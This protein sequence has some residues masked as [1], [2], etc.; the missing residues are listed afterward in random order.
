MNKKVLSVLL[1]I[2]LTLSLFAGCSSSLGNASEGKADMVVLGT[3]YTV[4]KD[5]RTASAAAIKDGKF[6]YVGNEDGIQEYIADSTEVLTLEEGMVL[7]SFAEGHGHGHEG[8]VGYLYQANLYEATSVEEYVRIIED[9]IKANP[10]LKFIRGAG[11][12]NGYCPPGGPT[13]EMLDAIDTDLPIAIV[14]GDHH[15]YWVNSKALELMGVNADTP[16]VSGGVIERDGEG[17]PTGTFR[18]NAQDLV[19]AIIPNYTVEEYK[20]GILAYQEEVVQYG[21]TAYYEPMI[22]LDGGPNL[23][24]AYK[25]L[26]EENKL[27][28]RVFGGYMILP[29][30]TALEE[31]D[32]CRELMEETAGGYFAVNSIKILV[33]GVVEGRTAYLLKDYADEPGYVGEP[34]WEPA[35]LNEFFAKADAMGIT[36]HTHSIGDAA[37]KM[38]VDACQYAYE[39]NGDMGNRHA[40]THLQV[41]RPEDI[42]RMADLNMVASVNTYWFCKEPGYFY[43]LEVPYLGEERANREYPMKSFFDAGIVVATASDFPVTVPSIPLGAIQTGVTRCDR[44]GDPN[45]LQNPD[46]RVTVEQMIESCTINP[47]YQLFSEES[48]GS[49]EVGKSADLIVLDKN[50]LELDSFEIGGA[51]V[52]RTILEGQTIFERL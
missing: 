2:A 16:D 20:A 30:D 21:I 38:T 35:Q 33:D 47:A 7:P 26:D 5:Q 8:G 14:S 29:G 41:V 25:E 40:I 1:A 24:Q 46:E 31:V 3:I 48:F 45:T 17:N 28:I 9:F 22:N 34:L 32:R 23:L 10:D 19:K 43:E 52:I 50:I 12:L 4:D 18:E 39:Q 11:W 37:T 15:S 51:A 6:V 36:V 42:E 13:A 27:I 44:F 49:I